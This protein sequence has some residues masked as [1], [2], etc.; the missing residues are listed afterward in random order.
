MI[1]PGLVSATFK[2][3]SIDDV[4]SIMGRAGLSV[5][6]WSENHHIE[7]GNIAM[8]RETAA[9]TADKGIDIAGYGSYYRLGKDMDIRVSLDTASAMGCSQ[10]RIWAGSKASAD[11]ALAEREALV[12]ELCQAAEIAASYRVIL[13]LEWHKETLTDTN[14]SGLDL[15]CSVD[16]PWVRTLWQPTQAL[17]FD[18]R[19][20][21]LKMVAPYLS[22]LH[23]YYWDETGRRPFSEGLSHWR[24]YFS[25]LD[26]V[27][28]YPALLEFVKGNTEEQFLMDAKALKELI[29]EI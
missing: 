29:E 21:G 14:E 8:A 28:V 25:V 23:V 9:K 11:V 1:V 10:M 24:K 17:S 16:D 22:Y 19:T 2:D 7:A 3:K 5:I 13:N 6:E 27:N 26:P 12:D 18:E 4:L 20:R 15:L